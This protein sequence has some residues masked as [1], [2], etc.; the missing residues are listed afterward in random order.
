M[1]GIINSSPCA[2]VNVV[3]RG[4]QWTALAFA[5]RDQNEPI[6]RVLLEAGAAVDPVDTQGNTPLLEC[7]FNNSPNLALIQLLLEHGADPGKKNVH[8]ASPISIARM[9]GRGD[10]VALLEG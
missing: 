9:M 5:A 6:S 2:D 7:V 10:L 1:F 4:Q 3:D 8:G